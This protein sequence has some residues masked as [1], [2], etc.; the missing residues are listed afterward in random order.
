[1][2]NLTITVDEETLKKARIRALERGTSVNA[3]LAEYLRAFAGETHAQAR[4][5]RSLLALAAENSKTG[6]RARDALIVR[7]A[8]EAGCTL[9]L[10]ED[11][12]DGQVIDGVQVENPFA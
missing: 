12:N 7:A 9:L 8:A 3:V 1:V 4:A 2:A 6:G 10:S 5:T 11:L